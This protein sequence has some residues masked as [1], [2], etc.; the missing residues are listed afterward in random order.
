MK[1]SI[2]VPS[3]NHS[4]YLEACLDSLVSQKSEHFELEILVYDGGSSDGSQEI[5][6]RYAQDLAF[7]QSQ[8]DGGQSA[9]L[10]AGFERASGD[11]LGWLN[12]DDILLPGAL[13]EVA[14]YF[15]ERPDCP[16]VYGDGVW[17]DGDGN[18]IRPKRE[19][20][21]DWPIYAFGYCY[22][23]QPAAFFRSEV[24]REAGGLDADLKTCMDNDLWHR[25]CRQ[26]PVEHIPLFLAAMRDHPDTKTNTLKADFAREHDLLRRRYIKC[27]RLTYNMRYVFVRARRV[28]L[29]Y[30]K[31][32]Y[33]PMST[34]E[35]AECGLRAA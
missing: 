10:R 9:A 18:V 7:W 4:A 15:A 13:D 11:V 23:P 24:Y 29:R 6:E 35:L 27:S 33:R 32:C 5:I 34:K 3:Y 14:R 22:I 25:L 21:F 30:R 19:I 2:V 12:S 8:P 28:W 31:G 1:I 26:G 17:I 16:L 20:A